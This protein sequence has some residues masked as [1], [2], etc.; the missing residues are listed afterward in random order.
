EKHTVT[1]GLRYDLYEDTPP[2]PPPSPPP[3]PAPAAEEPEQFVI[4]FSYDKCN[5][6]AEADH[7]LGEA[8][9]TF[10]SAGHAMVRVEGHTDTMGS[11]A[12]T[13][14]LSDCR[15]NATAR[16]LEGKGVPREA[17]SAVGRGETE[18][19][20]KTGDQVKE[21]QN[22]RATVDIDREGPAPATN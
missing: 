18:L 21:P 5:I 22:R 10:K 6:T 16:N 15:A 19:L 7:V 20:I 11:N 9:S 4:F 17:I 2:P 14:R 8:A 12:Y 1:V 3:P 13:Q